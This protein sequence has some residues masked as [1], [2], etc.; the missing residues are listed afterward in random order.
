MTELIDMKHRESGLPAEG[1]YGFSWTTFFFGSF[2]ALFRGDFLMFFRTLFV[3]VVLAVIPLGIGV[4]LGH[5]IWAGFYNQNYTRR[6]LARG[7]RFA[8]TED[9][10][11]RAC[12]ALDIPT[13]GNVL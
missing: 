8:G 5:L 4:I 10:N 7:Y 13:A 1:F 3:S 2:P 9:E 6:L 12:G 11:K